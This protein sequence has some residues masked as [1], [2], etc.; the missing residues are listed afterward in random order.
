MD[1]SELRHGWLVLDKPLGISSAAAVARVKKLLKAKKIGHGGTLDPL[2]SGVLPL[3][4][5]EATKTF[6]YVAAAEK[7]YHFTVAWGEERS[8]DDA[9]GT[10]T[11]HSAMRPS[12]AAVEAIL[13]EFTGRILQAPPPY[14]A[15]KL[16]GE[17]AY[18]R[19]RRGE[20]VALA[21]REVEIFSLKLQKHDDQQGEYSA[22]EVRCGKG[23]YVRALARDFGRKLG[24]YG[25][26]SHLRRASVGKF[27]L[28]QAISLETLGDLVHSRAP[29]SGWMAM[30][31]VLDDIPAVILDAAL[32][33]DMRHGRSVPALHVA[34]AAVGGEVGTCRVMHDGRMVALGRLS[35]GALHPIRVFNYDH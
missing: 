25:Y 10:P 24:C 7:T 23:T 33:A 28:S 3:A 4:L 21:P 8:T 32:A 12:C 35:G 11:A 13:P 26:I 19:A 20:D 6:A 22:F 17:R 30:E 1:L 14:S 18:A 15:V 2:A 27:A 34:S 9:Q 5:G 16:G 29:F 31:S